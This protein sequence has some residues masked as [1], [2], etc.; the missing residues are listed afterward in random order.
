MLQAEDPVVQNRGPQTLFSSPVSIPLYGYVSRTTHNHNPRC[1]DSDDDNLYNDQTNCWNHDD[2]Y[3]YKT[4]GATA[5][6]AADE[7][8]PP[9]TF[10]TPQHSHD[11]HW[12]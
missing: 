4:S 5:L 1:N 6:K 9:G 11:I 10:W 7:W 8:F 2:R 3:L 12:R